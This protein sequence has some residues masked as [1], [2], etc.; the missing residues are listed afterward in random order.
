MELLTTQ[1]MFLLILVGI[2]V[3]GYFILRFISKNY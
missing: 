3:A 1:F 2:I